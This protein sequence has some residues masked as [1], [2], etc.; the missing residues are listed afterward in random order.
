M[1]DHDYRM[2]GALDFIEER[3]FDEDLN[4]NRIATASGLSAY[5]FSRTFQAIF[6]ETVMEYVKKRRLDSAAGMLLDSDR[7]IIDI[8][9]DCSFAS[10]EAFSRAFSKAFGWSPGAFRRRRPPVRRYLTL[11]ASSEVALEPLIELEAPRLLSL[12]PRSVFGLSL[13]VTLDGYSGARSILR[14]WRSFC[15][16]CMS[17]RP[18][19]PYVAEL[20]GLG[21]YELGEVI[22]DGEPFEYMACAPIPQGWSVP[23]G[24]AERVIPGGL[25]AVFDYSGPP[26]RTRDA[27]NYIFGAW[28]PSAP[29]R[30]RVDPS[31]S[32]GFERYRADAMLGSV[33]H[34]MSIYVPVEPA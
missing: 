19:L 26:R 4:L 31:G 9:M 11:S 3:L 24:F 17:C 12:S 7:R 21:V 22:R 15:A 6:G 16:T 27:F 8:A 25:Y 29:Y 2:N 18:P 34:T 10:Q 14:L 32:V 33:N 28:F 13:R 1:I 20:Y 5:H 23:E 30:M